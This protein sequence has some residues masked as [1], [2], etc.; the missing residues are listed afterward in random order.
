MTGFAVSL[1]DFEKQATADIGNAVAKIAFDIYYRVT[2]KSPVKSGRFKGNWNVSVGSP[3][4]SITESFSQ[5]ALG[6]APDSTKINAVQ[7]TLLKV[8][9]TKPVYIC[10]GLPYAARLETGYSKQA[11]I[12]MVD[13]TLVEMQALIQYGKL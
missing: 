2:V 1:R 11:P 7:A 6:V 3:D 4:F 12:G 8:D 9:G 10:N 13:V 5:S